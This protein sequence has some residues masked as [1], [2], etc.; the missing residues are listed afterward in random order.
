MIDVAER[1]DGVW[2]VV[3]LNDGCMSGLSGCIA[4]ELYRNLRET[5]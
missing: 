3:E 1:E 4:D 2:R 5:Q